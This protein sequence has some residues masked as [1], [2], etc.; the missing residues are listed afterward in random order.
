M[1]VATRHGFA[2]R[3]N[4]VGNPSTGCRIPVVTPDPQIWVTILAGGVGHRFWPLST[5]ERPKQLLPLAS[6][7]PLIVDTI[8]RVRGLVASER[9]RGPCWKRNSWLRS[10]P[11]PASATTHSWWRAAA[12]GTGPV[13]ARAAWE[14]A[15]RDPGAVMISLHS[16][17]LI[18]PVGRFREVLRAAVEVAHRERLLITVAVPPDRPETGYGYIRPGAGLDA[19]AGHR[20]Y[21]VDAF[22]EKPGATLAARYV[23]EGYRWNSGIFVWPARTFLAEVRS[24]APEVGRALTRLEQGDAAAFFDEVPRISVDEAVL[25]RSSRVGCIDATFR[26]DD[27]G[28]WESLARNWPADDRGNVHAGEVHLTHATGNIALAGSGRLALIGVDDLLVVRTDHVTLVMPRSES[29]HLKR[30]LREFP[31]R[32]LRPDHGRDTG[33]D[34]G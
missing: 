19:P 2:A 25:E 28:S 20:A 15:K 22:V 12:R 34:E 4:A 14:V 5:P 8:E 9:V 27:V 23:E 24:C 30:Y 6:S 18:D 32:L 3:P 31:D 29:P 21:R 33:P 7:R 10:G 1:S 16:D 26:W 11:R 13:L 17:H